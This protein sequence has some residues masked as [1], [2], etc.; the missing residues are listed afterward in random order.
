[1][2][3]KV[4]IK[5]N[6]LLFYSQGGVTIMGLFSK[7]KEEKPHE[8]PPLK[9]PEFP[10]EQT[11][12]LFEKFPSETDN[13]KKAVSPSNLPEEDLMERPFSPIRKNI[14]R[15][16]PPNEVEGNTLF[17]KIENF[18]L[19]KE[20][21]EHIK[22]KISETEKILDKIDELRREE[23]RELT[24]WSNDLNSIKTRLLTIDKNLFE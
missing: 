24:M 6:K 1:M 11:V 18:R 3:K 14:I 9:F 10:K 19:V 5:R 17:V 20:K 23:E 2:I 22:D 16:Q 21:M 8:L 13:I 15:E 4:L 7:K 12:P